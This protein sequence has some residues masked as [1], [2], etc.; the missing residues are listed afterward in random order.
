MCKKEKV[1]SV[2]LKDGGITMGVVNKDGYL[3]ELFQH[4]TRAKTPE[5]RHQSLMKHVG[6]II[7]DGGRKFYDTL[8]SMLF[9]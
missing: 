3:I 9:V 5:E 2:V 8:N 1:V 6:E 7:D 4:N